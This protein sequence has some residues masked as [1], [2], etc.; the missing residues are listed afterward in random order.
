MKRGIILS[1]ASTLVLVAGA[2]A[3]AQADKTTEATGNDIIVTAQRVEQRLQ[4]VPISITV[5]SEQKL[6]NNNIT[7]AKDIATYTPGLSTNNRYGSDNTT[8]TIRGFTQEQR[9]TATVGTYFADVVAPRGSGSTQ[10]GDGAGP[11]ALFD[12]SNVQ[13]LK[14]PQGTLQGRNSTGGAVLLVPKKPTDKLE[15]YVEGSLGDYDMKRVQAVINLPVSDTIRIRLGVDRN[16]RD[17]YLKNVGLVGTGPNG[18]GGAM[19]SVDYVA[20]RFSAIVDL[21]PDLE[22]YTVATYSRSK[23]TGVIPKT[24]QSFPTSIFA[25]S[26]RTPTCT[27]PAGVTTSFGA[28]AAAQIAREKSAGFWSV[29][30]PM[31]DNLSNTEQEQIIN[32]TTWQAGDNLKIKNIVSYAE[33]RGDTNLDL[34]GIYA[35]IV[36]PGTETNA[37]QVKSFNVTHAIPGGHTNAESTFVEELQFQGNALENKLIWQGGLYLEISKP[38]GLTGIQSTTQTPCI[39]SNSFNCVPGQNGSSLGRLG[40]QYAQNS[41]YGRAAYFQTSY[42]VTS[43]LKLTAGLR[44][45]V[46]T[47][48]S[49]FGVTSVRQFAPL[50]QGIGTVPTIGSTVNGVSFPNGAFWCTN[51]NLLSFGPQGSATNPY[52]PL[53]AL[54]G[55]VCREHHRVTTKAPTWLIDLDYK[56][57]DNILL[58][59]KWS[60]GYRQGGVAG[61]AADRLQDYKKE[62]VDTYEVG[63]KTS[64]R[65]SVP[66]YFNASAFYN[67]FKDQQLQIGLQCVPTSACAQTTAILNAGKS[68]LKGFEIEAGITPFEGLKI[69]AS[70]AYLSTKIKAISD[71][72]AIVTALALPFTD[73]RP[74]PLGSPIPN[75]IPHKLVVSGTYTLPLPESFGKLSVGA[76]YLYQSAYRAV[77][78]PP[79]SIISNGTITNSAGALIPMGTPVAITP[80]A[81]ASTYGILPHQNLINLNV[82]WEHVAG[83]PVDLGFFV[84][85]L[86]K[87]HTILHA[88]VQDG[89]GFIS[90]IVGEPRMFG[91]RVRFKFGS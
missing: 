72:S 25:C 51:D 8:W 66:G 68:S 53:S 41:Y 91:F 62:V 27:A 21:T 76:T 20:A 44:Y 73:V 9:T 88:N 84:T 34:F 30:N 54:N 37:G 46:D 24:L 58:Y 36:T 90:N 7:S 55:S 4:D 38:L 45:T 75:A 31:P 48:D 35:P 61:F 3:Y 17:G 50:S 26:N 12:L 56:P 52:Q 2:P 43:Q 71:V 19:G 47:M 11:G 16:K 29:S 86:T 83:G 70:Y 10:G 42:N 69:D 40:Y 64:W 82:N 63:T 77:S 28:L 39:D 89:N 78:D 49:K 85:N 18:G 5:L 13:V 74:L 87:A 79:A 57:A 59:A 60:R 22:N 81:F 67:N 6:A 33:F 23:S 65:G 1:V 15:G 14:G 32:T 80:Y